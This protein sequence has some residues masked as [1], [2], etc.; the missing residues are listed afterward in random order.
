[1]YDTVAEAEQK[2]KGCV[3]LLKGESVLIDEAG[4]E[5]KKVSLSY[6]VLRTKAQGKEAITDSGWEFRNLGPRIGYANLDFGAGS[7]KEAAYITRAPVRVCHSTQGLSSKNVK[8]PRL[9]GSNKLGLGPANIAWTTIYMTIPFADMIEQKYP[10]IEEVRDKFSDEPWL[11]SMA[12]NR[13]FA[14]NRPDVGP[15]FIEYRGQNVGY[16]KDMLKW[17]VA[18]DFDYLRETMEHIKLKV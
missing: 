11:I 15:Y 13:Q 14:I 2:L 3:C 18:P 10:T 12:F 6:R 17:D 16:S 9:R 1:M 8:I 7:Y 5:N 4:G